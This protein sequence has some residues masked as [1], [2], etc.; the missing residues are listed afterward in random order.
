MY[1]SNI[2]VRLSFRSYIF[3]NMLGIEPSVLSTGAY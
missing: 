2:A 3:A 1:L